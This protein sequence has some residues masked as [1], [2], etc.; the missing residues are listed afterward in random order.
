MYVLFGI[1]TG[2]YTI[3]E[4]VA[5]FAVVLILLGIN[6]IIHK[7]GKPITTKDAAIWSII[8]IIAALLFAGYLALFH[9]SKD[10]EVFLTGYLIEKTLSID[11]LFIMMAVF[12]SFRIEEKYQHRVLYYGILV[13]LVLR[14]IFVLAGAVLIEMGGKFV[15]GIFG[16]MILWSAWKMIQSLRLPQEEKVNYTGHP[17]VK[18]MSKFF[19]IYPHIEN[20]NFLTKRNVEGCSGDNAARWHATPL[21]LCLIVMELVDVVFAFDSVP[22]IFAI[23]EKP[24]LV[25]TSS[26]FAILGLRSLYFLLAAAKKYLSNIEK[27]VIVILVLIGFEMIFEAL[28]MIEVTPVISLVVI[29]AVITTGVIISRVGNRRKHA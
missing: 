23:T 24:F 20:Q 11:N 17:I 6:L 16:V 25:Y 21:L 18:W 2:E 3:F 12:A 27:S 10:A 13:A 14:L 28:G 15:S 22:A 5:F 4:D 9:G 7:K 8:W 29:T 1:L 19:P 26:I